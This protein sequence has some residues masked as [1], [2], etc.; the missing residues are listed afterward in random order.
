MANF[1]FKDAIEARDAI[2]DSQKQ[3]IAKLYND[4]ADEIGEKA[5][6]YSHKVNASAP[7]SERYYKELERQ[8]RQTSQEVSNEVYNMTKQN[9]Y[10]I[11]D[12]VV[13]DNVA[14]LASF[15]FNEDGL[16]AAFSYVPDSVVRNIVTGQIYESGWS[17]SERIW[18]NNE[19]TLREIYTVMG[20]GIA[21]NKSIYEIAKELEAYV[22][23]GAK[24]PWNLTTKDGVKIYKK[25]IDYNAQRLA[26][27]L[28]QH[29]YQQSFI[30]TTKDNPFVIDY[31][32]RSNGSRVCELCEERD[33]MHFNK[34]EL[35]MDHPNGMCTM[36]P[37]VV[38]DMVDKL[39]DWLNSPEGTFPEIDLFAENFG[40]NVNKVSSVEDFIKKYGQ[41]DKSWSA[42]VK[43]L[44]KEQKEQA[45]LLKNEEGL[46]WK[47]F[48]EKHIYTGEGSSDATKTYN[49]VSKEAK[50]F[51]EKYLKKYGYSKDNLP[52][53]FYELE[54]KLSTEDFIAFYDEFF[55]SHKDDVDVYYDSLVNE[56]ANVGKTKKAMQSGKASKAFSKEEYSDASKAIAKNYSDRYSA[57]K[58]L[59]PNL[60]K[61][62][63]SLSDKEKYSV[64]EYTRNSNPINKS[65][66]GYHD[67][68]DRSSFLGLGNTELGHEDSWRFFE[69]SEFANKFGTNGHADYKSAV[70]DLTKA[71]EKSTIEDSMYLYRGSSI[72]GLAGLL[73]GDLVSYDDA[74]RLLYS[75]DDKMLSGALEGQVFTNHA[76]TSTGI[77]TDAGFTSEDVVYKIYAPR[78]TKGIY[79]E[80]A[81]YYGD[82]V[83]MEEALYKVGEKYYSVGSEAEVIV[84][85]GT[86]YRITKVENRGYNGFYVE[87]EVVDQPSYFASGLEHT[88]NNGL[89][90]YTK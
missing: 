16:N 67:H 54:E 63:D 57:D 82:T 53:D 78:G 89:T 69:T 43:G 60:D 51:E 47:Q 31:I 32:W 29:S 35:P 84:Q 90:S 23:P 64:W 22:R 25:Q 1:I 72:E 37:N 76:F 50:E 21:Q 28:A 56:L 83:G 27:T 13:A 41:S 2:M 44:T 48:Y 36:E 49:K 77:S 24:L 80:P 30:A 26:R 68:W 88:H 20:A 10:L 42:W 7:V 85:R 75:S 52:K 34:D 19:Q 33:G 46:T 81:S 59:R 79:A 71:I 6:F 12:A 87:M 15:G 73:E 70:Q 5:K 18:G 40:Y 3:Q 14:W 74:L 38:N 39:A 86:T 58:F 61:T 4:W 8:L 11:S 55:K 65:L 17:L 66:S 45:L 62:W 9:M